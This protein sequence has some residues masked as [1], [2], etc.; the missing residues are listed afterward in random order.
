MTFD[1]MQELLAARDEMR[2]DAAVY[3][4]A[5][6]RRPLPD[7]PV[8]RS[9]AN[10][11]ALSSQ[12]RERIFDNWCTH[13]YSRDPMTWSSEEK[14]VIWHAIGRAYPGFYR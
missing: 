11:A 13:I 10:P 6:Q 4:T 9:I 3:S 12:D 8:P 2:K 1:S 7:F 14:A 5:Q